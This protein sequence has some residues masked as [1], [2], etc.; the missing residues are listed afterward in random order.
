LPDSGEWRCADRDGVVWCAGG[1]A[2]AGVAPGA[3]DTGFRCGVRWGKDSSER[4]CVDTAPDYPGH[5]LRD[6]RFE[7]ERGIERWCQ[8]GGSQRHAAAETLPAAALPACWLSRDCGSGNCDRGACRCD[9]DSD[10][11]LGRCQA[12]YCSG[13]AP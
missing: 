8:A 2:P 11:Q 4:V 6:C 12:G 7:Q 3:A 13:G 5:G 9:R 10:C 1:Q